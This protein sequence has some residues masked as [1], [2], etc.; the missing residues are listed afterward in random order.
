MAKLV[1]CYGTCG[2]KY[3]KTE[4]IEVGKAKT[5]FCKSCYAEREKKKIEREK[6]YGSIKKIYNID[7]PTGIMLK[8]IKQ[9]ELERGYTLKNIRLT[10]D[11]IFN[12]AECAYP[13]LTGGIGLVPFYYQDMLNYYKE[14]IKQ[15]SLTPKENKIKETKIIIPKPS[16]NPRSKLL[17]SRL[18]K[19]E[20]LL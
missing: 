16:S 14:K 20:E 13:D 6:L 9:Y 11:Y 3:P 8:Q 4:M 5:R 15:K 12:I 18:I 7:F 10:L 19:M 2:G 1:K 17:K